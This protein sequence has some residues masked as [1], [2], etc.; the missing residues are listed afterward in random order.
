IYRG[1]WRGRE[2]T[3]TPL[4]FVQEGYGIPSNL[5]V[6]SGPFINWVRLTR[7]HDRKL[8]HT[9]IVH[10]VWL[11]VWPWSS[12]CMVGRLAKEEGGRM[13]EEKGG[14]TPCSL[15]TG[16][17]W[18]RITTGRTQA[19]PWA[20][21]GRGLYWLHVGLAGRGP[22]CCEGAS[23]RARGCYPRCLLSCG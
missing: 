8:E 15:A 10:E 9:L 4:I 19:C 14:H 3:V 17:Y 18:S 6:G 12:T 1:E 22:A 2:I 23:A 20:S 7:D 16:L 5:Y 13:G 21:V 11:A